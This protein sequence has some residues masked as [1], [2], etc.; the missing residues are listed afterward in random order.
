MES[1]L[2]NRHSQS[3][4][5]VRSWMKRTVGKEVACHSYSGEGMQRA[6]DGGCDSIRARSR[7]DRRANRAKWSS[8]DRLCPHIKRVLLRPRP[9]GH[10]GRPARRKRVSAHEESFR[11]ALKAGV[12]IALVLMPAA[13]H[14]LIRSRR[15]PRLVEF[16]CLRCRRFRALPRG[17]RASRPEGEKSRDHPWR[18][19]DVIAVSGDP[20]ADVKVLAMSASLCKDGKVF[21]T[22]LGGQKR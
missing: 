12:K 22:I 15:V 16:G 2:R 8:R 10:A 3:R 5:S 21:K 13:F 19:A 6:L 9:S 17:G 14:G 4:N 18:Y 1:S 7:F 20:L 11:K